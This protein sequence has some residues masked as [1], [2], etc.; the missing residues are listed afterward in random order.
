MSS[1]L[2]R[3]GV[4]VALCVVLML[5]IL[6]V[7]ALLV[8]A[9]DVREA[10]KAEIRNATG[11]DPVLAGGVS[12]H[13]F[14]SSSASF[15]DVSL[16]DGEGP[17]PLKADRLVAQLRF[18][19]LLM[20]RIEV[21]H[22]TLVEP[23]ILIELDAD[24][25]S[26]WSGLMTALLRTLKPGTRPASAVSFSE[27]RLVGG[28]AL[29]RDHGREVTEVLSAVDLSLAW[30]A[31]S[32]SFAGTGQFV[33]R[34]EQVD[35][36]LALSDFAAALAGDRSGIRLR[37][38]SAPMKL[39]FDGNVSHRPSLRLEG[40]L[41]ADSASL[42]EALHWAGRRTL[43]GGG[44]GRAAIKAQ[45]SVVGNVVSFTGLNLDLDGNVAEGAITLTTGSRPSLQGTLATKDLN[46]TPYVSEVR[47]RSNHD[48]HWN[49]TPITL[50]GL[51]SVDFDLRL[52]ASRITLGDSRAGNT[53]VGA[54]LRN[55]HLALTIGESAAFGGVLKG[56]FSLGKLD[57]GAAIKAEVR[58]SDVDLESCLRSVLSL[59]RLEGRGDLALQFEARGDSIEGL[60]RSLNGGAQLTARQG[61]INGL[62]VEQLLRRLE[63]RPLSGTGDFRAGRTPFEALAVD[64]RFEKGR[65]TVEKV[66]LESNP[67][68][69]A[70]GGSA[71]V[72]S[73][74]LDFKG[75][76]TLAPATAAEHAAF[77][78]PF[79]VRG[80]WEDPIML[81]DVASLIQRSGAAAPLLDAVRSRSA[82]EAARTAIEQI[83]GS[84]SSKAPERERPTAPA[85]APQQHSS[86]ID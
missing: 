59:R 32:T 65:A 13:P 30:P 53:A 61:A 11:F 33:W 73:R 77:E 2:K 38:T 78:L 31:M 39:A 35:V 23:Q 63:R 14:P 82:R 86:P 18:L 58:F 64:V 62:N 34:A 45:T 83:T 28:S 36:S 69:L 42:R 4:G 12:V 50:D 21:A 68:R 43:P 17:P 40:A 55:G 60:T 29:V 41:V 70:L 8:R 76:A 85:L 9:D 46:L 25:Q 79:V 27:I 57:T 3:V 22:I 81:P 80:S 67:V 24:G 56:S 74:Q 75:V 44:L 84:D 47:L 72:T 7:P 20:G 51:S 71:S 19:P 5:G 48:R 37:V 52:S 1:S 26:N 66:L 16:G 54:S 49:R 10:V 6:A 15:F